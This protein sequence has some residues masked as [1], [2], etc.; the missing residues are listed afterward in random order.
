MINDPIEAE[1]RRQML[2]ASEQRAWK[3]A[4]LTPEAKRER[5]ERKKKRKAQKLARRQNR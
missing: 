2:T 5:A 1:L 4:A 3:R